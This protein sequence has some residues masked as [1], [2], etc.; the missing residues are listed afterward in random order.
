M[1]RR[2]LQLIHGEYSMRQT[3]ISGSKNLQLVLGAT[4]L[5]TLVACGGGSNPPAPVMVAAAD[6][7]AAMTTAVGA[8]FV[9]TTISF[10]SGVAEFGTTTQTDLAIGGTATAQTAAISSGGKTASGDLQYGSCHFIIKT[11]NFSD[12]SALGIGKTVVVTP[13]E[14][15]VGTKGLIA[16][17]SETLSRVA[18]QLGTASGSGSV[19]VTITPDGIVKVGTNQFANIS[20]TPTTGSGT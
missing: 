19:R 4:L 13:C 14:I 12:A 20:L 1:P 11:S 5:A 9:G 8:V 18:M 10:P 6:T 15:T 16:N 7:T 3:F 17:N 2:Y